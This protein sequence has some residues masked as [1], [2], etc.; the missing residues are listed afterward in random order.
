M[1]TCLHI[2]PARAEVRQLTA[3]QPTR[4]F[5]KDC[6]HYRYYSM[7]PYGHYCH[8][9]ECLDVIGNALPCRV[10]RLTDPCGRKGMLFEPKSEQPKKTSFWRRLFK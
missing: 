5:C 10:A 8:H 1:K 9:P 2:V 4:H 6:Q 7:I 3:P